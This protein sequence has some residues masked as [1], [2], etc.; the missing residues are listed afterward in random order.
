MSSD[1]KTSSIQGFYNV[2]K[3]R[4]DV[5]KYKTKIRRKKFFEAV[6][7]E[8]FDVLSKSQALLFLLTDMNL[9]KLKICLLELI[10][11][12]YIMFNV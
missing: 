11:V 10:A 2:D 1:I 3:A 5:A 4:E 7:T 8:M 6:E 9:I 12:G